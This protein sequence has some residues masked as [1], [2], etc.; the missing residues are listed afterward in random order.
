MRVAFYAPLK[1]L[2]HPRPSGDQTTALELTAHLASRGH[3]VR[4]ASRFRARNLGVRPWAWPRAALEAWRASR[5]AADVWLTHHT[6]WKSPDVIGP[7]AA[8]RM[9]VPYAVFQGIYS[10]KRRRDPLARLGFELNRRALL[11]ASV[12][13]TNRL[14]DLENLRRLLPEERLCRVAPCIDAP[15]FA[16]DPEA[17]ARLRAAWNVGGRPVI[18]AAAMFRDDVK[19]QGLEYLLTR[20]AR[21]ERR[22]FE[23]VLAGDGETRERL[24]AL[25]RRALPGRVRFLGR[26][27]RAKLRQ[28]YSAADLFVFPGIRESLGMVYLEAQ[29]AGLPVAAFL[30][31]GIPEVTAPGETA[32]LTP[33]FDDRA[34]LEA[35]SRLLDDAD[36]RRTMG[37]AG[38]ARVA[39]LHDRPRAFAVVERRLND[40]CRRNP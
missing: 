23:L 32:L 10:T 16:H 29:A 2:D 35:V 13:F 37:R 27:E 8:R 22:D 26:V 31:G 20:L 30:N 17:R 24:E 4:V 19:T 38:S 28:V 9:G 18:L 15:A 6:Y 12:V 14:L 3:E 36:L 40:L 25:A 1:P 39:A 33:P 7:F 21:L 34:F 5:G 11:A